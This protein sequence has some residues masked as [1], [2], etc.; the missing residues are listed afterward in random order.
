MRQGNRL[1]IA[2]TFDGKRLFL[3]AEDRRWQIPD[4]QRN[5]KVGQDSKKIQTNA[6]ANNSE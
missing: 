1:L 3:N 2:V 4:W 6:D 5:N